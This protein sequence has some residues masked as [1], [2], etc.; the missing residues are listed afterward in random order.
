LKEGKFEVVNDEGI[1]WQITR[2]AGIQREENEAMGV[3]VEYL[4]E[5]IDDCTFRLLPYKVIRNDARLEL[6]DDFKF[7]VEI[8]EIGDSTFVQETTVWK[9]GQ[10][11]VAEVKIIK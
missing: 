11:I 6:G 7:I 3:T 2:K 8:V 1:V 9:T 4:V 5:W 10:Y